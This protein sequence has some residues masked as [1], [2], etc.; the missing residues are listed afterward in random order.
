MRWYNIVIQ[1]FIV[2]RSKGSRFTN[3]ASAKLSAC[4]RQLAFVQVQDFNF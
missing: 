4:V 3:I 2:I 1:I